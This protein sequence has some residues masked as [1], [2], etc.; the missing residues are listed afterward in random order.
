MKL[1]ELKEPLLEASDPQLDAS[2][3]LL[4]PD[5]TVRELAVKLQQEEFH[6]VIHWIITYSTSLHS[7]EEFRD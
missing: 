6:L 3:P 1:T 4:L 7:A 2:E 5:E